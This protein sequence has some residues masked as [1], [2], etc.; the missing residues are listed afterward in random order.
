[1]NDQEREDLDALVTSP[2]WQ[3]Y[4]QWASAESRAQMDAAITAA[5]NSRDDLTALRQLQQVIVAKKFI[6]LAIQWPHK[7]MQE[8][9]AQ[10]QE[11]EHSFSRRGGL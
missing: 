2:G 9:A 3:R 5:A 6:E 1:M 10:G 4:T 7:R 8:L 11:R